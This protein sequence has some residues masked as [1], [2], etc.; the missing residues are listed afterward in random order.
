MQNK[1]LH[2]RLIEH[3]NPLLLELIEQLLLTA[4]FKQENWVL[5]FCI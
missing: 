2:S 1:N 5:Q 3:L 4:Y